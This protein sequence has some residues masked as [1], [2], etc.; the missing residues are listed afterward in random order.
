MSVA[1]TIDPSLQGTRLEASVGHE[2]QH[3]VDAQAFFATLT[4]SGSFE[5]S[6]N[7]TVRQLE[8]RAYRITNAILRTSNT[9]M[10]FAGARGPVELGR[11]SSQ[12]KVDQAIELIVTGPLYANKLQ[13]RQF[14]AFDYQP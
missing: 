1:V 6:K 8:T 7:L 9:P 3:I 4:D 10:N 2:G 12:R 5:L 14:P 11:I 13:T